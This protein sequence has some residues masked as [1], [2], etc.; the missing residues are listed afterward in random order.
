MSSVI[1]LALENVP[2][3]E[4]DNDQIV[5][6][7]IENNFGSIL[8]TKDNKTSIDLEDTIE[9]SDADFENLKELFPDKI[10]KIVEPK[11]LK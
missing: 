8:I 10:V 5:R 11:T 6:E 7:F 4:K 3:T 2:E 1:K 9:F